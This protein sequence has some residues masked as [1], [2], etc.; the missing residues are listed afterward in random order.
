MGE[1][2]KVAEPQEVPAGGRLSVIIDDTP[3]LLLRLDDHYYCVEDLCTHD[4]QPLTTGKVENGCI[5]CPR[6][7]AAFNLKSGAAVR[8]PATEPIRTF[9]VD[10][11]ADGV[12]VNTTSR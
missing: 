7:G 4:S 8:M 11:R 12:F 10:A 6:H 1:W 3:A 9:P 2:I 5:I